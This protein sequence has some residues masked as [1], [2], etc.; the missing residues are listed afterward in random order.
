MVRAE[1]EVQQT[2]KDQ[3]LDCEDLFLIS[4]LAEPVLKLVCLVDERPQDI[5]GIAPRLWLDL[6]L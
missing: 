5:F 4:D 1:A 3:L 6:V 2:L